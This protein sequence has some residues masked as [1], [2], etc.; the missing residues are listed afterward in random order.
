MTKTIIKDAE[1]IKKQQNQICIKTENTKEGL[2]NL[3]QAISVFVSDYN[4]DN[5]Y[6]DRQFNKIMFVEFDSD[7]L[8]IPL[9]I[10]FRERDMIITRIHDFS[11]IPVSSLRKQCLMNYMENMYHFVKNDNGQRLAVLTY[12]NMS[13]KRRQ[14]QNGTALKQYLTAI[15]KSILL[16]NMTSDNISDLLEFWRLGLSSTEDLKLLF[17]EFFTKLSTQMKACVMQ[18]L[19][20]AGYQN[21][22]FDYSI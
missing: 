8:L 16:W 10:S 18:L 17:D 9:N 14:K 12:K 5:V 20:N 3:A 4:T 15:S 2:K 6:S 1:K 13:E 22:D 11:L 19:K 7:L 21:T